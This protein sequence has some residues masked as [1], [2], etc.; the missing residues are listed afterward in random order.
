MALNRSVIWVPAGPQS[1]ITL[2]RTDTGGAALQAAILN[3]SNADFLNEWEGTLNIN[4]APAPVS[5]PY[6]NVSQQARLVYRCADGTN[7]ELVI[8]APKLGIFLADGV[9]VDVTTIPDIQAAAIGHLLSSSLSPAN[10]FLSGLLS[11]RTAR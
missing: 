6:P 7:A 9:T 10:L 11:S 2:I 5:A 3:H 4:L 1:T 8:P